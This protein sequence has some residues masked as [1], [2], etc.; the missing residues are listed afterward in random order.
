MV[1]MYSDIISLLAIT[2][3]GGYQISIAYSLFFSFFL[4]EAQIKYT[5]R[6]NVDLLFVLE[7]VLP[8]LFLY[9]VN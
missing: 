4:D 8:K 2:M 5:C 6:E 3:R 9:K 1:S 7:H